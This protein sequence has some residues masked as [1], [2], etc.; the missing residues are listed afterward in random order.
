MKTTCYFLSGKAEQILLNLFVE[1]KTTCI[2]S[3]RDRSNLS[4]NW[5][6]SP[7]GPQP[8]PEQ[9]PLLPGPHQ[10]VPKVSCVLRLNAVF[11]PRLSRANW[12]SR[13]AGTAG[14]DWTAW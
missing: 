14:A 11:T 13:V 2:P 12:A 10:A 4:S 8:L 7:S 5:H 1:S 6:C 9:L 3:L